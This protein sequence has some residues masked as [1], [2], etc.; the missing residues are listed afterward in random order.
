VD[1]TDEP[2]VIAP[3]GELDIVS[4]DAL[5]SQLRAVAE[6]ADS[7]VVD[8]S[9]VSFIDSSALGAVLELDQRLRDQGGRLAVVA[10]RGTAA[11]MLLT[12]TGVR[13]RMA[14]FETRS[15]ALRQ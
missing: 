12:L 14:I 10:P 3:E 5:R 15:A 8:L 7:I 1:R 13:R 9:D 6:T 4:A 11:A 2:T